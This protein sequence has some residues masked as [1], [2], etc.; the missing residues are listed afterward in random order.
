MIFDFIKEIVSFTTLLGLFMPF[1]IKSVN[2]TFIL[3]KIILD[4]KI[5]K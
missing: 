3:L 4:L 1:Q 2:F 5:I